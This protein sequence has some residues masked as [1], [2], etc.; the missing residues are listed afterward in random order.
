MLKV[1]ILNGPF[2]ELSCTEKAEKLP[3]IIQNDR[4][5]SLG[6]HMAGVIL[7]LINI[8]KMGVFSAQE[9]IGMII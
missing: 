7:F 3:F 5:F 6:T 9:S 1:W 2:P 8:H 4:Q